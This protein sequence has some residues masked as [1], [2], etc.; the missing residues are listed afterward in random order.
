VLIE[1]RLDGPRLDAFEMFEI[2]KEVRARAPGTLDVLASVDAKSISDVNMKF[3]ETVSTNSGLP[4]FSTVAAAEKWLQSTASA[5]E[6]SRGP[7]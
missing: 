6:E 1:E 3:A 2:A 7:A 5:S 4:A